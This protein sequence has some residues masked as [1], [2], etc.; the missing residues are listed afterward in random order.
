M[1]MGIVLG[2]VV[3]VFIIVGVWFVKPSKRKWGENE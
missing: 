2:I 3:I 1:D